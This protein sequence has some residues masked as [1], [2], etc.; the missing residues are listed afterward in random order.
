MAEFSTLELDG[1][2]VGNE[3]IPKNVL[4]ASNVFVISK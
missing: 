2:D 1:S 4:E 3:E